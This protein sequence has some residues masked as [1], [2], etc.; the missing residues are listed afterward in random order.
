MGGYLLQNWNI[1]CNDKNNNGKIQNFI[2]STKTDSPTGHS[3]ATNLPQIGNSFMYVE[4][5]S[6]NPD[7]FVFVSFEQTDM[8]QISK[9]SFYYKIFSILTNDNLKSMGRFRV[10]LLLEDNTWST[11]YNIPKNDRYSEFSTLWTKVSL[12]F[13]LKNYCIKVYCDQI[14][15]PH[16]DMFFTN[17]LTTHSVY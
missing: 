9:I 13:V 17:I 4:T 1:K 5:S 16:A 15:T 6:N 10:H 11:R 14:D 3:G 12:N 2:K 8:I 7:N